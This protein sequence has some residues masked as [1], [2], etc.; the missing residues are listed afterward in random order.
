MH[1]RFCNILMKTKLIVV[2]LLLLNFGYNMDNEFA[3]SM[4]DTSIHQMAQPK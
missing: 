3:Y 2:A 1:V 4:N